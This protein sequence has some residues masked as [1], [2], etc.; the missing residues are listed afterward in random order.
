MV[1]GLIEDVPSV[2]ELIER[3]VSDARQIIRSRLQPMVG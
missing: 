2:E 3:I 1:A